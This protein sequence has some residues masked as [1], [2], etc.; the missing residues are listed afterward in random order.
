MKHL[1]ANMPA[2]R[3][4]A[5]IEIIPLIDIMFFLLAS[6]MLIS[7]S[8]I[9]LQG[10]AMTLPAK[11]AAPPP[12]PDDKPDIFKIDVSATGE[13][14]VDKVYVS[15]TDLVTMLTKKF[16]SDTKDNKDTRVFINADP[17]STHGMVID[18]LD[19]VRQIGIKKVSFSL[20]VKT[21]TPAS[22]AAPANGAAAPATAPAAPAA[23]APAAPPAAPSKP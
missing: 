3:R 8:M 16:A 10:M 23:P 15:P 17:A 18:V 1:S 12:N 4:K 22:A 21:S 6:F 20:K 13:Y 9:K 19:K 11:T 2:P 7:L 14:T 5:R